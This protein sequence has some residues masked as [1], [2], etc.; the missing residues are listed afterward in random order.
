[1]RWLGQPVC[2]VGAAV[3]FFV[4]ASFAVNGAQEPEQMDTEMQKRVRQLYKVKRQQC[5]N[6]R[7]ADQFD[8]TSMERSVDGQEQARLRLSG[9][10]DRSAAE[11]GTI[12][13]SGATTPSGQRTFWPRW[14]RDATC[15]SWDCG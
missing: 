10:L 8:V 12:V 1:M 3:R 13:R 2:E 14:F 15:H 5:Y 4:N 11:T 7:H 6:P 9:C